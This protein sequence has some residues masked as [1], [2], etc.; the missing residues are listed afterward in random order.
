MVASHVDDGR[1]EVVVKSSTASLVVVG[2]AWLCSKF[3]LYY[4]ITMNSV[5][6]TIDLLVNKPNVV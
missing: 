4:C 2:L 6:K 1:I 3:K 5:M